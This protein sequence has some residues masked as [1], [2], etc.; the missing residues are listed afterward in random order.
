MED[1]FEKWLDA[2]LANVEFNMSK[3]WQKEI[4]LKV[5]NEIKYDKIKIILQKQFEE[6]HE[7]YGCCISKKDCPM[8]KIERKIRIKEVIKDKKI[9][10]LVEEFDDDSLQ[11][12]NDEEF[13]KNEKERFPNEKIRKFVEI[14]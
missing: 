13:Y 4:K 12:A 7:N 11:I 3:I 2:V 9:Y 6:C 10:Y 5:M 8:L 1:K 14:D